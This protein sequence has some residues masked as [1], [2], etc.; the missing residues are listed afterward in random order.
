VAETI[1]NGF[2]KH[3]RCAPR[4]TNTAHHEGAKTRRKART[5]IESKDTVLLEGFERALGKW[6]SLSAILDNFIPLDSFS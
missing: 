1:A 4:N 5:A 2:F 3:E 6:G